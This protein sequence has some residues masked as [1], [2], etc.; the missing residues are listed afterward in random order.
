MKIICPNC[1]SKVE[2]LIQE[3]ELLVSGKEEYI[4]CEICGYKIKGIKKLGHYKEN[5]SNN[6]TS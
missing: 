6:R 4:E 3:D 1:Q 2:V 5:G